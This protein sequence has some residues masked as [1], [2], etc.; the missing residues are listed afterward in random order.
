MWKGQNQKVPKP[1]QD[2]QEVFLFGKPSIYEEKGSFQFSALEL[3]LTEALGAQQL[4][5][6]RPR[7]RSRRTASSNRPASARFPR[8]RAASPS[9]PASTAPPS[10][11]S[12]A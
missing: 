6:R 3:L 11:T 5:S 7:R 12:S 8:F 1:P 4:A 9:S 2:G 10:A